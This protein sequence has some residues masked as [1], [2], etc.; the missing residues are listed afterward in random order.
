VETRRTPWSRGGCNTPP[1]S[2]RSKPSRWC[3]T[4][5]AEHGR[6]VAVPTRRRAMVTSGAGS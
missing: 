4:T 6:H 5:R 2:R 3:E 1:R